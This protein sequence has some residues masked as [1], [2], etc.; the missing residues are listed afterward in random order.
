MSLQNKAIRIRDLRHAVLLCSAKDVVVDGMP[1]ITREIKDHIFAAIKPKRKSSYGRDGA[2]TDSRDRYT[3][4]ILFRYVEGVQIQET[5]W[6]YEDRGADIPRWFKVLETEDDYDK[7]QNQYFC[8][9]ARI[10]ESSDDLTVPVEPDLSSTIA[11]DLPEGVV[12]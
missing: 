2:T 9:R 11:Q 10:V 6:I 12:L 5:A 3:H 8:V 4:E 1:E 7:A